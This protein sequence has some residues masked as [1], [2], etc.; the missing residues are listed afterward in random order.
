MINKNKEGVDSLAKVIFNRKEIKPIKKWEF[1]KCK[2]RE[3]A[4][5][6]SKEI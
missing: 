3:R 6:C 5:K 4:I 1:F 2:I